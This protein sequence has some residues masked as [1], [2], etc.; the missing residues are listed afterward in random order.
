MVNNVSLVGRIVTDLEMIEIGDDRSV[1]NFTLAVNRRGDKDNADF[2]RCAVFNKVAENLVKY[3]YKGN[4]I[5]VSGR[6]QTSRKDDQ[7]FTTVLINELNF[8]EK[9]RNPE[10]KEEI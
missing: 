1:V 7:F 4:M 9:N 8:L 2:I 6:I 5:S 10:V 3:Q